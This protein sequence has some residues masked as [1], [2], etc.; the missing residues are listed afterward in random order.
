MMRQDL[1]QIFSAAGDNEMTKTFTFT[2]VFKASIQE[3]FDTTEKKQP[4]RLQELFSKFLEDRRAILDLYKL[5]LL[6]DLRMDEHQNAVSIAIQARHEDDI[7]ADILERC[8]PATKQYYLNG[9]NQ[10]DER[11]LSELEDLFGQFGMLELSHAGF[12]ENAQAE[13]LH[14]EAV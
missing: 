12:Q 14:P 2:M 8:S 11:K 4:R 9:L 7:L 1:S 6:G 13:D 3:E 10:K 5:W